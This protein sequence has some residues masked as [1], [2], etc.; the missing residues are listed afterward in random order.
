MAWYVSSRFVFLSR[1]PSPLTHH[2][3]TLLHNLH[4]DLVS[5]ALDLTNTFGHISPTPTPLS[6]PSSSPPSSAFPRAGSP[7]VTSVIFALCAIVLDGSYVIHIALKHFNVSVRPEEVAW[8]P[9]PFWMGDDVLGCT[10]N[11]VYVV[12]T[13]FVFI[14]KCETSYVGEYELCIGE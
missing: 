8:R 2:P 4:F 9:G 10:A 7:T 12:W 3:T 6:V 14:A 1:L 11:S 5:Y 13:A